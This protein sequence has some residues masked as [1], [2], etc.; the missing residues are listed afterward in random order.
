MQERD[1]VG[2]LKLVEYATEDIEDTIADHKD[3]TLSDA[4]VDC[5]LARSH[6]A[7]ARCLV[8]KLKPTSK[9]RGRFIV[10]NSGQ[11]FWPYDPDPADV[12]VADIAH[13]L[14]SITRWG[15]HC[16]KR[17]SVAQHSLYA[18]DVAW[19]IASPGLAQSVHDY[20]L[21]HD[22]HEAYIG[23][24]PTP[25]KVG[26]PGWAEVEER[27]QAAVLTFFKLPPI[28]PEIEALVQRADL[29]T[30]HMEARALFSEERLWTQWL[31]AVEIPPWLMDE[32]IKEIS[33]EAAKYAL[34]GA[35]EELR[36]RQEYYASVADCLIATTVQ[37][38]WQATLLDA[39]PPSG[40][41]P[42]C[43]QTGKRVVVDTFMGLCTACA[44]NG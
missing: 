26:I 16:A 2:R 14:A 15:G 9:S 6:L 35:L 10:T 3:A 19:R 1:L 5:M 4:V 36:G 29:L 34:Y 30:L 42:V 38:A 22:A 32:P 41:C 27:V 40:F 8:E 12:C 23:D 13:A 25:I 11:Q 43:L 44:S 28:T 31:P 33:H 24:I 37:G 21:I 18:A 17:Y 20:A 7:S 39:Q